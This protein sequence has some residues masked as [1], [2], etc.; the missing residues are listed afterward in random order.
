MKF[1]KF[2]F[3]QLLGFADMATIALFWQNTW[4]CLT[5]LLIIS[6]GLLLTFKTKAMLIFFAI[7]VPFAMVAEIALV[8]SEAWTYATPH[9][10]SIPYWL[11]FA[12]GNA[13]MYGI[14]LYQFIKGRYA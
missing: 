2:I 1:K 3:I 7:M 5:L 11:P 9:F 10:Q 4:V 13:M 6:L 14:G 8:A 12:W